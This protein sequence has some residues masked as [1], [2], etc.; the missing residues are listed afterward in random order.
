MTSLR[1]AVP[2]RRHGCPALPYTASSREKYPN[3]PR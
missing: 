1:I 3:F 2:Q